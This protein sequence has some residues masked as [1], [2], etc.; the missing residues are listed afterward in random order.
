MTRKHTH[1]RMHEKPNNFRLKY[2]NQENITKKSRMD[3]QY[4]K[5]IRRTRR[6]PKCKNAHHFTQN[7]S[8]KNIKLENTWPWWN[9][10]ILVPEIHLHSRQICTKNEQIPAKSTPTEWMTKGKNTLTQKDQIKK[11]PQTTTEQ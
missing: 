3:I 5:I 2:N 4:D 9:T 7:N 6:T 11:T 1:N 10:W 8:K